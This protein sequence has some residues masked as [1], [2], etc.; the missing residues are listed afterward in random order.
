MAALEWPRVAW[1]TLQRDRRIAMSYKAGFALGTVGS[2]LSML[3]VFFLSRAVGG[4]TDVARYGGSYFGFALVGIA[5]AE[6]MG[7]GMTGIGSK[8]R[9]G[10]MTGTLE[11]ML[12]SPNRMGLL[13][14]SSSLWAHVLA[15]L[16]F[17]L[18]FGVAVLL[19]LRLDRVDAPMA[20]ASLALSILAF[21]GLGL[22]SASFVIVLKQGNPAAWVL[23]SA[24]VLLGGVFYPTSV[25]P[26][27]LRAL[28]QL[29]PLTHA[30]ELM[31]RSLLNGEGLATL[32]GPFL[33][34]AALTVVLVPLG[35]FA[36]HLAVR[37][38]QTD[39]S[40]SQY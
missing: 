3:G 22:L 29:L 5:F 19:G 17:A 4:G 30:L 21:N 34:L 35:L 8:V 36:C 9:E 31:R 33:A 7:L 12:L 20:I 2:V 32:W 10:Q 14:L 16:T 1:A 26:D 37:L 40:L 18:N 6:L 25:L 15:L 13:L 38:A 23:G 39:G 27:W 24:S 28:G 11:L